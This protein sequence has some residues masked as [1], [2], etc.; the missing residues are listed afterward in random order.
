MACFMEQGEAVGAVSQ[1]TAAASAMT[2][3]LGL[4]FFTSRMT[5]RTVSGWVHTANSGGAACPALGL[6]TTVELGS[7]IL[8][9]PPI[10]S[11]T[12]VTFSCTSRP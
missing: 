2:M 9:A 7:I 8:A 3:R 10:M 6:S 12:R 5:A 4:A 1:P 11:K